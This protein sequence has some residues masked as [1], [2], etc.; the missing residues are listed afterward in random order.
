MTGAFSKI[1]RKR[2]SLTR[3]SDS[4]VLRSVIAAATARTLVAITPMKICSS[5]MLLP[6]S[7]RTKGP[8]SS[9]VP[10]IAR[11]Q[12][13]RVEVTA[14]FGSSRTAIQKRNGSTEYSSR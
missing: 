8:R 14:L 5:R 2:S 4:A 13:T 1:M 10:Q 3:I 9:I 11:A 12:T 6:Q 7:A